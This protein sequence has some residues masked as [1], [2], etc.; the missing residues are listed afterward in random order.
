[1]YTM[2]VQRDWFRKDTSRPSGGPAAVPVHAGL[3]EEEPWRIQQLADCIVCTEMEA[4]GTAADADREPHKT[5]YSPDP[6]QPIS[7]TPQ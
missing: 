2:G 6:N 5:K 1:M 3:A 4:A 7:S